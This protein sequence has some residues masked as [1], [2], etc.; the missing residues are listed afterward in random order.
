MRR[1]DRVDRCRAGQ[2]SCG[3]RLATRNRRY[4]FYNA[5]SSDS[6]PH[7]RDL[8]AAAAFFSGSASAASR[9]PRDPSLSLHPSTHPSSNGGQPVGPTHCRRFLLLRSLPPLLVTFLLDNII[10]HRPRHHQRWT[11]VVA[12]A[13]QVAAAA[14]ALGHGRSD[15]ADQP[16]QRDHR[17]RAR[18]E[19]TF[20]AGSLAGAR[21]IP[22]AATRRR[23]PPS[24]RASSR[25]RCW[26][27][28]RQG[29]Q[30]AKRPRGVQGRRGSR[31]PTRS[32][33]ASTPGR[34]RP[35]RSCTPG[36][37]NIRVRPSKEPS[38][39]CEERAARACREELRSSR[40]S[41]PMRLNRS[42][43]RPVAIGARRRSADRADAVAIDEGNSRRR[44]PWHGPTALDSAP[45]AKVAPRPHEGIRMKASS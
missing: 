3:L 4:L 17:R 22:N 32:P 23:G 34:P 35:C 8:C 9:M 6:P 43:S 2:D 41:R 28:A 15:A 16:S 39:K 45:P 29:R 25:A 31:R 5:R 27:Y 37:D 20:A 26:W 38:R 44:V 30:S 18:R 40:R 42:S 7:D 10:L 14:T 12:E 21:N 24:S 36:R 33:A 13:R 11:A 1:I 19:A